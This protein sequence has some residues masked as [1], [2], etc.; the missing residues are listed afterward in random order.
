MMREWACIGSSV[1]GTSHV[2]SATPCQD[3]SIYKQLHTPQGETVLLLAA[4]DGAGSAAYAEVGAQLVG[5]QMIQQA[6]AFIEGGGRLRAL[7]RQQMALWIAR[8]VDALEEDAAHNGRGLRDY[9]STLLFAAIGQT[10]SAFCQVGDGAIVVNHGITYRTI[11]WP[12]CG[13]YINSTKFLT[14]RDCISSFLFATDSCLIDEVAV[15]TDGIQGLALHYGTKSVHGPFFEPM[16]KALRAH[17]LSDTDRMENG[18][19]QF[20]TGRAVNDRTD[21]DKTLVLASRRSNALALI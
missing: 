5:N 3:Y 13:E 21:D 19:R 14:D 12:Q 18:L 9:A 17:G 7:D 8:T 10:D 16:F 20:L 15:F 6:T 2:D 11:F 1:Q 4:S